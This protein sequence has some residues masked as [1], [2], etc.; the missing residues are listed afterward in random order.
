MVSL[1]SQF[2][3]SADRLR[4]A[5]IKHGDLLRL[6][7]LMSMGTV[8]KLD[9]NAMLR[10]ALQPLKHVNVASLLQCAEAFMEEGS[11]HFH[12]AHACLA[13]AMQT[14]PD[15]RDRAVSMLQTLGKKATG[16]HDWPLAFKCYYA[17]SD[18]EQL[19]ATLDA[20]VENPNYVLGVDDLILYCGQCGRPEVLIKAAKRLLKNSKDKEGIQ[21]LLEAGAW[22]DAYVHIDELMTKGHLDVA[23]ELLQYVNMSLNAA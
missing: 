7:E 4:E 14:Q 18:P 21:L 17:A 9:A 22:R 20:A 12:N 8:P 3:R 6:Y 1:Y 15:S 19:A 5:L 2:D 13:V 11:S 23:L 10:C 16:I